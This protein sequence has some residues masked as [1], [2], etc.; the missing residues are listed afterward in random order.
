MGTKQVKVGW[1]VTT[2]VTLSG[3]GRPFTAIAVWT[4]RNDGKAA[5]GSQLASEIEHGCP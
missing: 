3:S 2:K 4:V 1:R 5:P